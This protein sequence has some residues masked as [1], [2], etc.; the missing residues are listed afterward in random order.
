MI[1]KPYRGVAM[2]GPVATWYAK[3]TLPDMEEHRS[4]ARTI[5]ARVRAG[6]RILEVA[7]G[8]GYTAIELARL[9]SFKVSGMDIS[10]TFVA[11]ARRNAKDAGVS[12]EFIR[13][14]AGS[15]P[16]EDDQFDF[17][18]CRAA[19]KN[20]TQPQC[21][22]LEMH[23]VLKQGGTALIVD[24]RPDV[25]AQAV[26]DFNRKARRTG[27]SAWFT[28]WT[29]LHF[30]ARNAHSKAE[31]EQMIRRTGFSRHEIREDSLGYE[32]WLWKD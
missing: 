26:D 19:F 23:R 3:N 4:L 10:S 15:M 1:P 21:A 18:V 20:F 16:W 6:S 32:V 12:V 27:F 5:A 24:L 11:I 22:L 9:G 25:S 31:F 7:P 29:F 2:E 13:G 14:D 8:P 30:L 17:L 28:K